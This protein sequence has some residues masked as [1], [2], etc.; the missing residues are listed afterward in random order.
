MKIAREFL[1]KVGRIWR[2]AGHG[3]TSRSAIQG[4]WIDVGAHH[5]EITLCHATQ[6][7][8]L[9]VFAF[10]PN[11]T[12]A[13]KLMG[14]ASN[15]FVIPMAVAETDGIAKL[16]GNEF[17]AA[18]S[19]LPFNEESLKGWI[20]GE[21]LKVNSIVTVPTIRLDTFMSFA[22]IESVDY[23][24][25]DAQGADLA[26]VKSA[27]DRLRDIAKITLEVDITPIRL[28]A[29]APSKDEVVGFLKDFGFS[30]VSAEVQSNAQE[31]NL[32]FIH[33]DKFHRFA[34]TNQPARLSPN[35]DDCSA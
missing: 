32:T 22:K 5:G 34:A 1:G 6:N 11:L 7:P 15:Y 16:Y 28:Y 21:S 31:E 10:E 4:T 23:L 30:L 29:G 33:A 20:G 8:A 14:R 17:D 26:V 19:L 9:R 35:A 12:A 3:I 24:K 25:I 27:G 2:N 13:A 18:S